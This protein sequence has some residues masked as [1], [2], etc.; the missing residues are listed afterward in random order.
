[1]A[2]DTPT[3]DDQHAFLIALYDNLMNDPDVSPGS[4][5]W[6]FLKTLAAGVTDNHAHLDATETDLLPDSS[7]D[8]GILDRWGAIRGVVRKTATPARKEAALRVFGAA[9]TVVPD[10]E[11]L[12][13]ASGL[14]FMTASS[15][16]VGAG[17]Y[18]DVDIVAIDVGSATRLSAGEDLTFNATPAG[19][20]ET[21]ELQ[22]D[23]DEDG[24]DLEDAG[25][26][27]GRILSRFSAP[28]LGGTATDYV[29]WAISVTGIATAYC[30]PLRQGYGSVD[31][32][33]L[34]AGS[35]TVRVMSAPE[36][37]SLQA[38]IDQAAVP[39]ADGTKSGRPVSVR[40]FRVLTVTTLA[41]DVE[42]TI[43][44][45]GQAQN[46]F[47]WDDS[48]PPNVTGWNAGTRTATLDVRPPS[49]APGQR[50]SFKIA[51]SPNTG[52][53]E[54]TIE[55]LGGGTDII[56]EVDTA[57]DS[58]VA[59]S[60]ICYSGGPL[61]QSTR[62]A[63]ISLFDSLGTANPDANRYGAWEGNYR[64]G[65]IARVVNAVAG[66]LDSVP[67]T[68]AATVEADDPDYPDDGTIQLLIPGRV[69]VRLAH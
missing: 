43:V 40:A 58:P 19:L 42:V 12:N 17:G 4:F 34:H 29:Q 30:Y 61:V 48:T 9:T 53:A 10:S 44:P 37:A 27:R 14:R 56:L 55:A 36:V 54:R 28:P 51:A 18:V 26:Y 35:G 52:G 11:Q 3:L 65:A 45:D 15:G 68:P 2:F 67:I 57:G 33:A 1:M 38:M 64:L 25:S 47:D 62:Q 13:H 32:A 8:D 39:M 50:V 49:M 31:L 46:A 16:V 20:Q 5:N 6:L 21:A 59:G 69:L 7:T 60:T 41:L 24:T 66:V 23:M 22:L 63:L